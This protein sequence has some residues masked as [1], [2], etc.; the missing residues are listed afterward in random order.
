MNVLKGVFAAL[1][2]AAIFLMAQV[3]A[4]APEPASST[5]PVQ[6]P[7]RMEIISTPDMMTAFLCI[8]NGTGIWCVEWAE[9][10]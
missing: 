2:V 9:A 10:E 1:A 3:F 8:T 4:Q 5:R 7:L 6:Q